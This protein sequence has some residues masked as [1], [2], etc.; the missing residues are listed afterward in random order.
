[1]S[2]HDRVP[3]EYSHP[4]QIVIGLLNELAKEGVDVSFKCEQLVSTPY[5]EWPFKVDILFTAPFDGIL[6]V[7]G[8]RWH[9]RTKTQRRKVEVKKA[10]LEGAGFKYLELWDE[11]PEGRYKLTRKRD[12]PIVKEMLKRFLVV[13]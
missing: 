1:M 5:R 7:L 8:K 3:R 2:W 12:R 10:C 9:D 13:S 6:E 11:D 4:H